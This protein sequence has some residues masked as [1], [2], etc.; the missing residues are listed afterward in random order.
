MIFVLIA[1]TYA[2]FALLVLYGP[3]ALG[4]LVVVWTGAVG[5]LV[6]KLAGSA[7]PGG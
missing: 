1:G 2:P 7:R 6:F 4:T 3:V 5:G